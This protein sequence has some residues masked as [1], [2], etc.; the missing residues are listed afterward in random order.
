MQKTDLNVTPYYDDFTE[1]SNFHR[2]LF[3]PAFSIQARELTQMQSILQNQIERLGSHFFKEG[4]VVIPGQV[5]FDITYSYV[6]I[7][8]EFV[9]GAVTHTVETY[10]ET[11]VGKKLKGSESLVVAKV[12][13]SA[14]ATTSDE[15][16]LFVKYEQSNTPAATSTLS[17][18][19]GTTSYKFKNGENIQIDTAFTYT[20][21]TAGSQ[22]FTTNSEVCEAIDSSACGTGSSASVQKG[23]FYIRGSFVQTTAQTIVLDK[24]S[25]SPSYRVGFQVTESLSTPEEDS[26]LLDNAT[27]STNFA[28]KGAHRLKYSLTLT[29]KDIGSADDADFIELMTLRS[30]NVES[31]VRS[32]EYSVLEETLARRT[33]DESGDYIVRGFNLDLREHLDDGLNDGVFSAADGGDASKVAIGLSPGKAYVRG[34]EIETIGQTFVPLDK[35]RTTE[36]TQNYPTMF[37][38]GNFLQVENTYNTPD[39][40]STASGSILPFREVELRDKR[41]PLTHLSAQLAAS[42]KHNTTPNYLQVDDV[43]QFPQS[44][45]FVVNIGNE[46]INIASVTKATNRLVI[47]NTSPA[48]LSDGGRAYGGSSGGTPDTHL[49]NTPVF[50]WNTNSLD[51][52]SPFHPHTKHK[53]LGVARTRAFEH[54]TGAVQDTFVNGAYNL[55]GRFQHYL[56][57]V[58]MLAKIRVATT[59]KLSSV[60]FI[61]NGAKVTGSVS[62]ATGIVYVPQQ[63]VKFTL[64]CDTNS[65]TTIDG[66]TNTGGL[67]AGM[68]ISGS[69]IPDHTYIVS[70]DSATAITISAAASASA[71]ITA[72]IGNAEGIGEG[73]KYDE[74]LYFHVIQTTGTFVGTDIISSS[75]TGDLASGSVALD[76]TT[77]ATYFTMGDCHSVFMDHA[78]PARRYHADIYPADAKTLKGTVSV[79]VSGGSAAPT[80]VKGTNTGFTSDLKVGDLFEVQ[81]EAGTV[82]R[83]EVKSITNDTTLTT[84]ETFPSAVTN[85]TIIRVRSKLE[86]QEELVM[87]SKLPKQAVKTLKPATLNNLG[88]TTL[89]VRR[90]TILDF[91]SSASATI[92]LAEGETFTSFNVDDIQISVVGGSSNAH[93]AG[94]VLAPET[95]SG[96]TQVAISGSNLTITLQTTGA[97]LK[98]VFSV[99]IATAIEKTK[100]LQPMQQLT[101]SNASGGIY[102][103]N[104]KDD[105]I[106][107]NKADIFKVRAIYEGADASTNPVL[108]KITYGPTGGGTVNASDLFQPGQKLTTTAAGSGAVARVIDGGS[109]GSTNQISIAYLTDITFAVGDIIETTQSTPASQTISAVVTGDPNILSNFTID[110]GMRDTYYDIGRI[111]R[112]PGVAPP[113][114]RITIIYEYFTHGAGDYFSVDSYPVGTGSNQIDYSEIPLYSAQ[115]VDPDTISPTGEYDL[116]DAVDFRPRV[117]DYDGTNAVSYSGTL[118][119]ISPFSFAYRNYGLSTSSLTDIPKTDATFLSSFD[120]YLPQNGALFLDSEGNFQTVLGGAAENPEKPIPIDDAMYLA[121][122]RL[123]QYTFS[124]TDV[125][126]SKKKNRRFTMK[127]IGRIADRVENLEYYTQLNMLEKSTEAFQMQDSD[128]LD[129]F[130]NGFI[131]DN[132]TGHKVGN[133]QHLDYQCSMDFAQGI[134]RPE[135]MSRAIEL[136]E[137]VSTDALRS[138]AGYQKTGDLITLPYTETTFIQQP[139][140]SRIENV[141]P[142]NVIAWIGSLTLNPE[143]DIWK[144]TNRLP[145]LIVNKEGNYDTFIARNGGSAI[146]TVWNE[147]ETF[148]SGED[149]NVTE[150]RDPSFA[151]YVPGRGRRVM[152]TTVTTTTEKLSRTGVRT[153]I[154]PRI[155]YESKGDRV[156]STDILPYCRARDVQFTGSVFKPKSR[157]YAFFDNVNVSRFITPD[158]PFTNYF[159]ATTQT[160]AANNAVITVS[161]T[162]SFSSSGSITVNGEVITYSNTTSTT[163]TG[164]SNHAEISS[165]TT[166]FK[167]PAMGDPLITGPTGKMSGKFS[168]PD[169]NTSGNP[170]F[171]VGERILRLTSDLS[172]G[173][174]SGDT[175]T[176]GEATYYAKG[177][178]DNI[179]ETIIA[180]RN[181]DVNRTALNQERT[182]TSTR[183]SD[184]QVGW[185]DPVAQ[186]IMIDERGGAFITSVEVYFQSKSE[187][188]PAVC[189]IRTM[190]G[191]YPTTTILPFGKVVVEPENVNIS[192]DASVATK[193]TFPSPVYLQQDIEYC[194]VILANTQDYHIWLSHMG[195]TEVG[196]TRTISDNPYAGVLF[197]SQNASTWTASQMEDLKFKVNRA[198]FSTTP[199]TVTLQNQT[200][201]KTTLGKSPITTIPGTKKILVHHKNHGMYA[202]TTN[203]VTLSNFAGTATAGGASYNMNALNNGTVGFT[204]NNLDEVGLDHYVINLDGVTGAPGSNFDTVAKVTGGSGIQATENYIIDTGK[205]V[206]Q[207]MELS[208]TST[209]TK[210][211]TTTATSA[212]ATAGTGTFSGVTGGSETSFQLKSFTDAKV[213][214]PNENFYFDYP[215]MVASEINESLEMSNNKSLQAQVSLASTAE[216]LSPVLDTQRMGM[217]CVQNRINNIQRDQDLYSTDLLNNATSTTFKDA[218][219][220]STAAN[221]DANAAVYITRKVTLA[222]ASTAL[223]VM[224]DAVRFSSASIDVY[225]KTL[226]ADDTADFDSI[227]FTQMT[228]D[229]AVSDSKNRT[230]FREYTFEQSGLDGFIAFAIK[231]VMRGTSSCE[232]PNIRDFRTIALAL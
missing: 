117:G 123:P 185:Y 173:P 192:D 101:V 61:T 28:A 232:V 53:T 96:G 126:V 36:F 72:T 144:D 92:S 104:F 157:L 33:F 18:D 103:T 231:I 204:K 216:N 113:D 74:G 21:A 4:A 193:F 42:T 7:K 127:D 25:N 122:F 6:K 168:I 110:D 132:F 30:G 1:D 10:R 120:Y 195:D 228:A 180:T 52:A 93:P 183:S 136:E 8:P 149:V 106:S 138:S 31:M 64:G 175:E 129:R 87:I 69:G 147:W 95:T 58:R 134:L 79:V 100:T 179:Q 171:K 154:T 19:Q 35:A 111:A 67:E 119:S 148:W 59:K 13:G 49:D 131:V 198:S 102:G 214:T 29:K 142:F 197:K 62:G 81:D 40:D 76:S 116:R 71:T 3:R 24:Y 184:R 65:N 151:T 146:N 26:S 130:K 137:S 46:L 78:T 141:N 178:L 2:V 196:G 181:A 176:S 84:H 166:V 209:S 133:P 226:R 41:Q 97:I 56:F 165:G 223:K 16:T 98:V 27:G 172:N 94:L 14:A 66:I 50:A 91:G 145:N 229:T 161:S 55:G 199:G 140:A 22:T 73:K 12:V 80:T 44:G 222:N 32:T 17:A 118:K 135:Y 189:Q 200:L 220:S 114:G 163:F 90:Q 205:L 150:W 5:G 68:G 170:A 227:T 224:F 201:P 207:L 99:Q 211:R 85:S 57:D 143:S 219:N 109:V 169:P 47:G 107:L 167:T 156:V 86:E 115:R 174:L 38:A 210:L 121:D 54:S 20:H 15:L 63:D 125:A 11:L 83:I 206:L 160:S 39:I 177:L 158:V 203:N 88:D 75:V 43:S 217:V 225:F 108:P 182:V 162:G 152:E 221:G 60:N 34:F 77:P 159:T 164:C 186:S 51:D 105:E 213:V 202:S 212:S 112:K 89:T 37:S 23:V 194:F 9:V 187:I 188:V 215:I 208:G 70:V 190:K 124:P 48:G 139:Y 153:E 218:Y 230:D 191:G 155:D 128:G 82:K 45:G